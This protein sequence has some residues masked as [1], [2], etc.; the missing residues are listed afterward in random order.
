MPQ[1]SHH[2]PA[3]S[4][5]RTATLDE[6]KIR[7]EDAEN[8]SA[9]IEAEYR[10]FLEN[11]CIYDN[12]DFVVEDEG[13]VIRYGGEAST[14]GSSRDPPAEAEKKKTIS[15][16]ESSNEATIRTSPRCSNLHCGVLLQKAKRVHKEKGMKIKKNDNIVIPLKMED[17]RIKAKREKKDKKGV[18]KNANIVD[19]KME[20][21][22]IQGVEKV[23]IMLALEKSRTGTNLT[24]PSD[25]HETT[26]QKSRTRTTVTNPSDGAKTERYMT[27]VRISCTYCY[28]QFLL[29]V[30]CM[31]NI[32]FVM[33]ALSMLVIGV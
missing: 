9:D 21:G 12:E 24:N 17:G 16:D 25:G 23:Q 6:S 33:C 15:S 5:K 2:A 18:E 29:L 13:R 20:D 4:D 19:T 30:S 10:L 27:S 3:A 26:S 32:T 14:G 28:Y 11:V 31:T 22:R 7:V 1:Q 8:G